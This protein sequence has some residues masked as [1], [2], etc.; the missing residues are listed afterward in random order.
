L[1]ISTYVYWAYYTYMILASKLHEDRHRQVN[2]VINLFWEVE[3]LRHCQSERALNLAK[4]HW[5]IRIGVI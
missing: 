5:K 3:Q 1:I 4:F 2:K